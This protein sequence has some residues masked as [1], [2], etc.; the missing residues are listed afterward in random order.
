MVTSW[1]GLTDEDDDGE[2]NDVS[3]AQREIYWAWVTWWV[4]C[5]YAS[6]R[7]YYSE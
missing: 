4:K 3:L 1:L 2:D 7:P 6:V 5:I